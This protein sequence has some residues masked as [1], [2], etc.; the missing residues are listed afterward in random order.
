MKKEKCVYLVGKINGLDYK[1]IET[2]FNDKKRYLETYGL[3]VIN[4]ME[5]I[6]ESMCWEERRAILLPLVRK[7]DILFL[8]D[9]WKDSI[10]AKKEYNEFI[11]T[12]GKVIIVDSNH[13]I[14]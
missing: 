2:R 10:D 6:N 8:F 11:H 14:G 5:H 9:D 12:G 4:P 7:C 13:F 3:E 1:E